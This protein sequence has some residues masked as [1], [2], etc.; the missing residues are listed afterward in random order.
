MNQPRGGWRQVSQDSLNNALKD[1]GEEVT[2]LCVLLLPNGKTFS[3]AVQAV[4]KK[5]V[6]LANGDV[7]ETIY[8]D[9]RVVRFVLIDPPAPRTFVMGESQLPLR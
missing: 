1:K 5:R 7:T 2:P 3:G 9:A 4:S 6:E 8:F